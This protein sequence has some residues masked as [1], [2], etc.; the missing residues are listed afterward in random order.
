MTDLSEEIDYAIGVFVR[1]FCFGKSLTHPYEFSRIENVWYLR[2]AERSNPRNYRK[3]EWVA[4]RV[5]PRDVDRVAREHTRGRFFVCA[6]CG[7]DESDE[8]MRSEF[9]RLGY[10]L[11]STEPLFLHC[12][13]KVPR[14]PSPLRIAQVRSAPMAEPLAPLPRTA[15]FGVIGERSPPG[16]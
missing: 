13:K 1:G 3:E 5:E 4:Y 10:R 11:L 7:R 9:K 8:P 15:I 12:L 14:H 2:D 16:A 6:V